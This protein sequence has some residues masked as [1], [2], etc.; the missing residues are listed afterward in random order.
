MNPRATY[1]RQF[2]KPKKLLLW[3]LSDPANDDPNNPFSFN[4]FVSYLEGSLEGKNKITRVDPFDYDFDFENFYAMEIADK[5]DET[6]K[7]GHRFCSNPLTG[8]VSTGYI[9][10]TANE[11]ENATI[12]SVDLR[13]NGTIKEIYALITFRVS[14]NKEAIKIHTLCGNQAMIGSGE[15]TR[16]LNLIK[17]SSYLFGIH[18][19]F[20]DP[21]DDAINYY[22][23]LKF[24]F[25]GSSSSAETLASDES[26]A[27][28]QMKIN[29]RAQKR[30]MLSKNG[31]KVLKIYKDLQTGT[32]RVAQE[33]LDS[34][35]R[36]QE[37]IAAINKDIADKG[38]PRRTVIVPGATLK[39]DIHPLPPLPSLA[40]PL[41]LSSSSSSSSPFVIKK[42]SI[43]KEQKGVGKK[44]FPG[45]TLKNYIPPPLPDFV[46]KIRAQQG[47]RII[48]GATLNNS[49][50][51]EEFI[52]ERKKFIRERTKASQKKRRKE[53][54]E[55]REEV[56]TKLSSETRKA[57]TKENVVGVMTRTRRRKKNMTLPP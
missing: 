16:L 35:H 31:L 22:K 2:I 11:E 41:T 54:K 14:N 45:S 4:K 24:R 28:K 53:E 49:V 55:R 40:P 9:I 47:V 5:Y 43:K 13:E 17:E 57:D 15:G 44:I 33:K 12:L 29:T 18:K 42:M 8:G 26:P 19:I 37:R 38:G 34:K 56:G 30:W 27:I 3:T 51:K 39:K 46:P 25:A 21:L 7:P 36:E 32:K 23:K 52:K 50:E 10:D 6:I 48:P 20:L 1:F